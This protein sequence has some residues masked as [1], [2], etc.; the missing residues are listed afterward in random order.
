MSGAEILCVAETKCILGE[1]PVW[2]DRENVLFF[3]DILAPAI[4]RFDPQTGEAA[5]MEMPFPVGAFALRESEPGFIAA[6]KRGFHFID[7]ESGDLTPVDEFIGDDPDERCND[8]K[9]DAHGRF[10]AGTMDMKETDPAGSLYAVTPDAEFLTVGL[11]W[12]ITNGVDFSADGKTLYVTDSAERQIWAFDYDGEEGLVGEGRLFA[13]LAEGEGFPDGCCLDA[14]DHYWGA[15]WDGARI[16][17][18]RPDGTVERV[19]HFPV[20][21]ITSCCFGGPDLDVLYVTSARTGLSDEDLERYP[22]SG[23]LFAV[24]GLGVKGLKT[25]RFGG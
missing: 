8:G 20:P 6:T 5:W 12:V 15:H 16:T 7:P 21:R 4:Y 25:R 13:E 18:Y 24:T 22:L 14:E 2:D 9:C 23:A 1:G 3:T 10:W 17:R 19:I 11:D